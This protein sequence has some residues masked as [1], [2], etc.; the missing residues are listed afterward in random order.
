MICL[1][2]KN[3]FVVKYLLRKI[4]KFNIKVEKEIIIIWFWVFII[5]LWVNDGN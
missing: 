4:E 5:F 2:K 1:L 3:F